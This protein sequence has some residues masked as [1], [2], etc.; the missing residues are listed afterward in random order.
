MYASD[1]INALFHIWLDDY[2]GNRLFGR[3]ANRRHR[4]LPI[5]EGLALIGAIL[6]IPVMWAGDS[7]DV[8]RRR[9]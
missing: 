8:G 5:R 6:R 9:S 4:F 1:L 2:Y 7:G 3:F